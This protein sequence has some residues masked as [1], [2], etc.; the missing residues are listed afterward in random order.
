MMGIKGVS[1]HAF[2]RP[3]RHII[4]VLAT[5]DIIDT[6]TGKVIE[7]ITDG[8]SLYKVTG[9]GVTGVKSS[10]FQIPETDRK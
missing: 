10:K 6:M 2:G 3:R 4:F 5:R 8:I 9:L 7:T 1:G